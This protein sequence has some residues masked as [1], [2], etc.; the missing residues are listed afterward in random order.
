MRDV[1]REAGV[2]I[3]TV[4]RVVN[5]Q[6]EIKDETR[7][8]VLIAINKLGYRPSKVAR[9]LVTRRTD[10]IGL[11]FADIANPYFAE[12]AR[13]VL[14]TAVKEKIEVFLCN[15]DGNPESER[16]AINSL[17]D[18]NTDGAIAFPLLANRN[19]IQEIAKPDNP[20]VLININITPRPGLGIVMTDMQKGAQLAID[21]LVDKGHRFIGMLAGEVAPKNQI[22][23]VLGYRKGLERN[24]IEYREDYVLLGN[25]VIEFGMSGTKELLSRHS[26]ITALFCYNDLIAM[27][28]IE[29]CKNIGLQVPDDFAIVGFDNN[30]FSSLVNPALTT[31]TVDK[32]KIGQ[33]AAKS[34]IEMRENPSKVLEP[35]IMDVELVVRES[36]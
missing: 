2:S 13:G 3:K 11:L 31:V 17:L 7:E 16:R 23:R 15:T 14:D 9:A 33:L 19:W 12:V 27:G 25:T 18:H 34:L 24:G 4:S 6:G 21:H 29:T 28:A 8:R 26:E 10:T 32:Y 36:A 35:I 1:A 20:I 30:W 5:G 22:Q